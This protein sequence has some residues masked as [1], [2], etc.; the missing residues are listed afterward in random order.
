VRLL[1]LRIVRLPV[2][3]GQS[4]SAMNKKQAQGRRRVRKEYCLPT[5]L[6]R[7]AGDSFCLGHV[8]VVTPGHNSLPEQ[9]RLYHQEDG[10]SSLPL[11]NQGCC[12][13]GAWHFLSGSGRSKP[14]KCNLDFV[15]PG[16]SWEMPRP[17]TALPRLSR[18]FAATILENI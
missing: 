3:V 14:I 4:V 1:G 12:N 8:R 9:K 5:I 17:Y 16:G 10:L 11:E 13:V 2:L 18:D 15:F 6:R 7:C